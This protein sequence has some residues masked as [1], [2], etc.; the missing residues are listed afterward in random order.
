MKK[1]GY[2]WAKEL[3]CGVTVCDKEAKIIYINDRAAKT[4]AKYGDSLTGHSLYEFHGERAAG[5]INQML[6]TGSTNSY[7]IEKEGQKKLIH[8]MPWY[9][10]GIVA[11]L[12]ELSLVIPFEMPHFIRK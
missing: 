12:V 10:D 9:N 3:P 6:T 11:G 4:F 7:T 2:D 8:Q 1:N 5:M